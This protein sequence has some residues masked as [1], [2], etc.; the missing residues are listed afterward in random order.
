MTLLSPFLAFLFQTIM[1]K[2]SA[3]YQ[4][5]KQRILQQLKIEK[6]PEILKTLEI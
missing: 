4:F 6:K 5:L 3:R 1:V 2:M